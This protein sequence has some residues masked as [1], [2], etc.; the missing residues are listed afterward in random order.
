MSQTDESL[1]QLRTG[2]DYQYS[3]VAPCFGNW[4]NFS[5]WYD[6]LLEVV[7]RSDFQLANV[8][9]NVV[10]PK[11]LASEMITFWRDWPPETTAVSSRRRT[12]TV[13]ETLV[14]SLIVDKS[15]LVTSFCRSIVG[16]VSTELLLTLS[17]STVS[18]TVQYRFRKPTTLFP[19]LRVAW[20]CN[21]A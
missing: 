19:S 16:E 7:R 4:R 11:Y 21:D 1:Q 8:V 5:S 15:V 20:K 10:I 9:A 13:Q 3:I 17:S 12:L 14:A 18:S 6:Y 2:I